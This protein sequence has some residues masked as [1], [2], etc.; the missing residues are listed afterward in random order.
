M[1]LKDR[2]A[3]ITGAAGGIG[4]VIAETLAELGAD[5]LLV[6]RPGIDCG[7]LVQEL[8]HDWRVKVQTFACDLEVQGDRDHLIESIRQQGGGL[9]VLINNAAFVGTSGLEGW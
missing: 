5:L 6:D 8:E 9:D 1:S 2:R 3:L 7:P 4:R